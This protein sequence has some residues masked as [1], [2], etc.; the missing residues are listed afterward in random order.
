MDAILG[1]PRLETD[2]DQSTTRSHLIPIVLI[3]LIT[4]LAYVRGL[5]NQF[6]A[7]DFLFVSQFNASFDEAWQSMLTSSRVWP[8]GVVYRW[9]MFQFSGTSPIGYHAA[10]L[11]IHMIN[12]LLV[13]YLANRLSGDRRVGWTAALIFAVYPRHHQPVLWMSGNLVPLST[14]FGLIC[15]CVFERYL[16]TKRIIWYGLTLL[17]LTLALLSLEGTVVLLPILLAM[18]YF[19]SH[20][21]QLG[22][23]RT[24]LISPSR[25]MKYIPILIVL[26]IFFF[27]NFG[28]ARAYKLGGGDQFGDLEDLNAV[29]LERGDSYRFSIGLDSLKEGVVYTVYST[30]PHIPLRSLDVNLPVMVLAGGTILLL[31]ALF[32][33]GNNFIRFALVWMV[34]SLAPYVFFATF[35]NADRYFYLAAV[36]FGFALGWVIWQVYDGLMKRGANLARVFAVTAIGLYCVAS[37]GV[38]QE[39]VY[40]WYVAGE[41]AS[42]I[43]DQAVVIYPE[44]PPGSTMLFVGL[45]RQYGQAYVYNSAFVTALNLRYGEKAE[46]VK[47]YQNHSE[48]AVQYLATAAPVEHPLDD[49]YVLLYE[50]GELKDKT[51][52]VSDRDSLDPELWFQW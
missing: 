13:F 24:Y 18:E 25:L 12:V 11:A 14:L 19:L 34:V 38:L 47:L 46:T 39:R 27:I 4:F 20:P 26:G 43:L 51:Q 21:F 44:P 37:L 17:T 29:G 42:N 31:L 40:E 1:K 49:T 45:P 23:F 52:V 30:Y 28:G 50:N 32:V 10:S 2:A 8:V 15:V 16:S 36:G 33:K 3:T 9:V 5:E 7:E 35:G 22:K 6:V 48:R 41:M